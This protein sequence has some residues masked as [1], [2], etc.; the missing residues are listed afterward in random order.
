MITILSNKNPFAMHFTIGGKVS[1]LKINLVEGRYM[2]RPCDK[3]SRPWGMIRPQ[4][5][6]AGYF[7]RGSREAVVFMMT[8]R[9]SS[10]ESDLVMTWTDGPS[11]RHWTGSEVLK[12][13]R[14]GVP[15]MAER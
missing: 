11:G 14:V 5:V 9:S 2:L 7:S 4:Q 8:S 1:S 15:S 12:S 10:P 3:Q 6:L 13:A